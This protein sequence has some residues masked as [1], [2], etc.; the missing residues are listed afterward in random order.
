MPFTSHLPGSICALFWVCYLVFT[1]KK[2]RELW[3][4]VRYSIT[5]E[6]T[7]VQINPFLAP[8]KTVSRGDVQPEAG[9]LNPVIPPTPP[10]PSTEP[11]SHILRLTHTVMNSTDHLTEP[12]SVHG[13]D[14]LF[15]YSHF[16]KK[17]VYV[18]EGAI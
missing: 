16:L 17:I 12:G 2:K 9:N 4:F 10:Y 8:W 6:S 18:W 1:M 13:G 3:L 11:W 5:H 14:D 7:E 15:F